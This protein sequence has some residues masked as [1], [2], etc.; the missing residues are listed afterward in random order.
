MRCFIIHRSLRILLLLCAVILSACNNEEDP[1]LEVSGSEII[2][3]DGQSVGQLVISTNVD[4]SISG[5]PSW[6]NVSKLSGTG[7]AVVTITLTNINNSDEDRTCELLISGS[8][9]EQRVRVVN[10]AI[11]LRTDRETYEIYEGTGEHIVITICSSTDWALQASEEVTS[12]CA[13]SKESGSGDD[14]IEL[15]VKEGIERKVRESIP[16]EIVY[17]N[18]K[19]HTIQLS[20]YP[21]NSA[22]SQPELSAPTDQSMP[23]VGEI[24]FTWQSSED[25]DGDAVSYRVIF[26]ST[27]PSS[28]GTLVPEYSVETD[29]T[30]CVVPGIMAIGRTYWW[31]V[32]A[33]DIFGASSI[34]E[35][36][37]FTMTSTTGYH[38]DGEH[39]LYRD[40]SSSGNPVNLVFI[41]D[42]FVNKDYV[43][44]GT[45]DQIV[46][47]A[48]TAFFDIEP[49]KTF[50]NYFRI[51]QIA[52]YSFE[53]GATFTYENVTRKTRFGS[54]LAGGSSTNIKANYNDIFQAVKEIGFSDEDLNHTLIILLINVDKYA[55]TCYM[56]SDG[57]AI[58]MCALDQSRED[59]LK[60]LIN[61][62]AGGHGFGRLSDEYIVYDRAPTSSE[63]AR[64]QSWNNYPAND[65]NKFYTNITFS[66]NQSE[67]GWSPFIGR[68][69]YPKAGVI[70]GA[71][72][73]IGAYKCESTA[74]CMIGNDPYYNVASR[75]AIY[76]RIMSTAGEPYSLEHFISIDKHK[77]EV[78]DLSRRSTYVENFIPLGTP[79]L[80]VVN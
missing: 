68:S 71:Y 27:P 11:Y 55:G 17:G 41:G 45:F 54:V 21:A 30:S 16:L 67:A 35:A 63:I 73:S 49:Y 53:Q 76:R 74:N 46:S 42:G 78:P 57:K 77:Y 44:G 37:T 62:E 20:Y 9:G 26:S 5:V 58:A 52:A 29:G 48:V 60:R 15:I 59:G 32:E 1:Q 75:Y 64:I 34:S 25:A 19:I 3:V 13:F 18:N 22:P 79:I 2:L 38:A 50:Q 43:L 61:H 39:L 24:V 4:W 70:E 72:W 66:S 40:H 31:Q 36:R 14:E 10:P 12:W 56:Q 6:L 33:S 65:V 80:K 7:D 51:Y 28:D 23:D 47:D 69:E 8:A